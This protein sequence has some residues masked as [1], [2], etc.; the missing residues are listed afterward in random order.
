[1]SDYRKLSEGVLASP[2][3]EAGQLAEAKALGVVLVVNNRPDGEE[4]GQPSGE[5]IARAA[6]QAG[7]DYVAIPID[8]SGYSMAQVEAMSDA[9]EKAQGKV[10]AYCRT[11]TR[12]TFL[13]ALASASAGRDP[14]ELVRAAAAAGYDLAPIEPMLHQL[15][16][17]ATG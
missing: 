15:A 5:E 11:G 14:D 2:Q 16:A 3:I 10:L 12:S 13:W 9:L 1:V 7:V 17:R 8:R 4:A 6:Q